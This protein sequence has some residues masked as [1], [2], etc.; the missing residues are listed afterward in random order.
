[1]VEV[2]ETLQKGKNTGYAYEGIVPAWVWSTHMIKIKKLGRTDEK[3]LETARKLH[4]TVM[5]GMSKLLSWQVGSG[6]EQAD[7]KWD[8]KTGL[9]GVQNSADESGLRID[10]TQHQMHATILT[11]RYVFPRKGSRWPWT[12]AT[13]PV[14]AAAKGKL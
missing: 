9:G 2:H 10:V 5:K 14:K 1:M 11:R 8:G 7:D 4:C 6:A 3:N 12:Q 13:D